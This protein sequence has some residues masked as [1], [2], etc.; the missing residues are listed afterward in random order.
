[1][2]WHHRQ[3]AVFHFSPVN[4]FF[5]CT[6]LHSSILRWLGR[7]VAL[8]FLGGKSPLNWVALPAMNVRCDHSLFLPLFLPPFVPRCILQPWCNSWYQLHR[9]ILLLDPGNSPLNGFHC[10]LYKPHWWSGII[11]K[12]NTQERPTR[13]TR[14]TRSQWW[15]PRVF[16]FFSSFWTSPTLSAAY[17]TARSNIY[18]HIFF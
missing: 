12:R 16:P 18:L 1:M 13:P 15:R 2:T 11:L 6:E 4:V 9:L 7:V 3:T 5:L 8:R 14:P 17:L 10:L